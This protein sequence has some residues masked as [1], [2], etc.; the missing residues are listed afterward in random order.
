MKPCGKC[1]QLNPDEASFCRHC[2]VPFQ[3][4]ASA[5]PTE[6]TDLWRAFIG[7][8]KT[9]LFSFKKGWSW[10]R[11]D[12]HYLRL[13]RKF[14]AGR[15]PRFAFTWN[16][17]AFVFPPF[18][19]FLYRKMYLYA[20]IYLLGP[21]LAIYLTKNPAAASVWSL[22]AGATSNYIYYWHI[23]E[24]LAQIH[25]KTVTEP[26]QRERELRDL[27]GVQYYVLWLG[28]VLHVLAIAGLIYVAKEGDL[29]N[30]KK[31]GKQTPA[32]KQRSV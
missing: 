14:S 31:P 16:W 23:R 22:V 30:F 25:R 9:V 15:T 20:G 17:P 13:F 18:L 10:D 11:A 3:A 27:G 28:V 7:S 19:W 26:G 8:S 24:Q 21:L 5:L 2:G 6:E 12:D 4:S 29:E 1:A 32:G